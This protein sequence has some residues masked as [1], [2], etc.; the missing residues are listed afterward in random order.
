MSAAKARLE[1]GRKERTRELKF[2]IKS[3]GTPLL[4]I[5]ADMAE[6]EKRTGKSASNFRG[7]VG[8]CEC[9][10][11]TILSRSETSISQV[12]DGDEK[13]DLAGGDGLPKLIDELVV[14]GDLRGESSVLG[15]VRWSGS[16]PEVVSSLESSLPSSVG[17]SG[18]ELW[19][20][21]L[22]AMS[23]K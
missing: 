15:E 13:E 1:N 4:T 14:P 12:E 22:E 21:R 11:L 9:R 20:E 17:E 6:E 7:I 3:L 2:P 19:Y 18:F 10:R 8:S 5:A 16:A 23:A